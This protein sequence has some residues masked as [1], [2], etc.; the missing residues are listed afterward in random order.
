MTIVAAV[1]V[2][3]SRK[4]T[5]VSVR[6]AILARRLRNVV[7]G[8]LALRDVALVARN[9][10][11]P[12]LQRISRRGVR[13]HRKRRRLESLD[14]VARLAFSLVRPR[15]ELPVMR[16]LMAVRAQSV[17]DGRLEIPMSMAIGASNAAVL[18][19][20]REI[21]LRVI[22]AFQ[23]RH[24]CPIRRVVAGLARPGEAAFVRV[25]MASS[26]RREGQADILH[27]RLRI[28]HGGM[29]LGAC[30]SSVSTRQRKLRRRVAESASRLPRVRVVARSTIRTE[31]PAMFVRMTTLALRRKPKISVVQV[32]SQNACTRG[33][34]DIRGL[35]AIVTT[36]RCVLT[37]EQETSLPMVD[38]LPVRLPANKRKIGAI[39]F[40]VAHSAVLASSVRRD[41]HR[42]HAAPLRDS[43]PNLNMTVEALELHLP[44]AKR[45]TFGAAQHTRQRFMCLRQRT[46]RDLRGGIRGKENA[47]KSTTNEVAGSSWKPDK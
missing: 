21:R 26:A 44:P 45:V 47:R 25:S 23:L 13:G 35:V 9:S 39:V 41:P 46:R 1:P 22:E 27:V 33:R 15:S 20:Q 40:G 11:M 24:S 4:L 2:R 17:C 10:R 29:A 7:H 19:Q 6:V 42:M 34:R 38:S 3:R 18:A 32:F 5:A 31:L 8:V 28:R 30:H 37:G 36:G 12:A 43:L 16:V 14:G